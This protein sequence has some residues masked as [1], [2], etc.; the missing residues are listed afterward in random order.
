MKGSW[1]W[2]RA[3]GAAKSYPRGFGARYGARH[4]DA[5]RGRFRR[6]RRLAGDPQRGARLP[7]RFL[8]AS[9]SGRVDA[10]PGLAGRRG[11]AHLERV[12][13]AERRAA[14]QLVE[15]EADRVRLP[16]S[17][18]LDRAVADVA[19]PT[20]HAVSRG[21]VGREAPE[22]DALHAATHDHE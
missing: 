11:L 8:A 4:L 20:R 5:D 17:V 6:E 18:R 15:P 21:D 16:F 10:E 3:T 14:A 22:S 2:E 12:D 1:P 9:L 7:E 13:R 19:H